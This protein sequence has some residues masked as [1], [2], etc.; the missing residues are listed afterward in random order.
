MTHELIYTSA[1][2]GLKPGSHGFCTVA[3]TAGIPRKLIESLESLSSYRHV[4]QPGAAENPPVYSHLRLNLGGD[5]YQLLSYIA[6]AGSDYSGRSNT[7]AH[8]VAIELSEQVP[9]GPA[10]LMRQNGCFTT[11]WS[12]QPRI[13]NAERRLPKGRPP[14][15]PCTIW[16]QVTG[17]AGW[18]AVLANN[19]D[20][21]ANIIV[22]PGMPTL[23]LVVE[24]LNL[25]APDARWQT[26]FSTYFTKL[27]P[28]I[29]CQWRFLLSGTPEAE[30]AINSGQV[31]LDLTNISGS[32]PPSAVA[33]M[34]RSGNGSPAASPAFHD[35]EDEWN[36]APGP[37]P[38]S[39]ATS[40]PPRT[41]D[42]YAHDAEA[43]IAAPLEEA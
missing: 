30:Q 25:L 6:D 17:D 37:S 31:L 24:A 10:W 22:E 7:L 27:P 29:Q 15:Q 42:M 5:R 39:N 2:K 1:R 20:D 4:F 32:P 19:T 38:S 34:A 14:N 8:H 35:E 28:G 36:S 26:T 40:R 43:P 18:A 9:A 3:T 41:H 12:G 33:E 16:Q 23:P 21:H 11:A 13:L